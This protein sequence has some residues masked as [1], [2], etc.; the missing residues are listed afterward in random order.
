MHR[1]IPHSTGYIR[2]TVTG[3]DLRGLQKALKAKGL[4]PKTIN[5]IVEVGT[6]A[7]N[8]L[9]ERGDLKINPAKGLSK[10]SG[11]SAHRGHCTWKNRE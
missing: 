6:I 7:F 11:K 2:R 8:W 5:M 9:T 1:E 10:F 3:L 4:K